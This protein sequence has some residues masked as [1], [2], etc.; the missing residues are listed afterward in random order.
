M[1]FV[2]LMLAAPAAI[3][4]TSW[5]GAF[6]TAWNDSRN[7]TNGVPDATDLVTIGPGVNN[8]V[9]S[10]TTAAVARAI[11]I[12]PGRTLT[13]QVSGSLTVNGSASYTAPFDFTAAVNN[14]GTIFNNGNLIL[15]SE[16]AIGTYGIVNQ[17]AFHNNADGI[18]RVD[19]STDT[20]I[21]HLAGF[22]YNFGKIAIGQVAN[23]GLHGIWNDNFFLNQASGEI[24]IG[25]V[26]MRGLVNNSTGSGGAS[27]SFTNLGNIAIG[28][29]N[30]AGMYGIENRA[31]FNSS[32]SITLD[33][34]TAS[35]LYNLGRFALSGSLV[36]GSIRATGTDGINNQGL[37]QVSTCGSIEITSGRLYNNTSQ[38]IVNVGLVN[39]AS[40]LE[41]VAGSFTNYG[42]LK[43]GTLSGTVVN[44][45]LIVNN[46]PAAT[47]VYG[48][49]FTGTINGIFT[50][51]EGT[52]SAG[53]FVAP[54]TI[55][56]SI[57]PGDYTLYAKVT[58]E[59]GACV[60]MVPFTYTVPPPAPD[61]IIAGNGVDISNGDTTPD[62]NDYTAFGSQYYASGQIVKRFVIRNT[63]A[64]PLNLTGTPSVSLSNNTDFTVIAEPVSPIAVGGNTFFEIAFDPTSAGA[65][66]AIVSIANNAAGKDP[67]TFTISGEGSGVCPVIVT[68]EP[69]TWTGLLDSDWNKACNWS[70]ASVPTRDNDVIIPTTSTS[71]AIAGGS[72]AFAKSVEL[73]TGASLTIASTAS[74]EVVGTK[75][76]SGV[77]TVF[78]NGGTLQNNGLL[79]LGGTSTTAVNGLL[80]AGSVV[81]T[82]CARLLVRSGELKN[83]SS[84]SITSTGFVFVQNTLSNNG[85]FTNNGVLKYGAL[86]GTVTNNQ[87]VVLDRSTS[88]FSY[89]GSFSGTV[90][91]IFLDPEATQSAGVFT[92]PNSFAPIGSLGIGLHALFAKVTLAGSPCEYLVA[93]TYEI[94]GNQTVWT[95]NESADWSN[96]A[97]WT[98]GV[99]GMYTEAVIPDVATHDP[100]IAAG[101]SALAN[102][103]LVEAAGVL[104]IST[105]GTLT[106]NGHSAYTEPFPF[107]FTAALNNEGTVNNAGSLII[108]SVA[109]AGM[110]GIVNQGSLSNLA[111][112][113][114][115]VDR[116]TDTG[117]FNAFGMW[118]NHGGIVLGASE[119]IGL[120][121][122]WND[123]IFNNGGEIRIDRSSAR[124]LM[125]NAD[126]TKS[127]H[128][129]FSN[130]A[131]ITIGATSDAGTTGIENR[132][133]FSNLTGA[134]IH[135]D[136][137][138]ENAIYHA[139]GS[140]INDSEITIGAAGASTVSGFVG[141]ADFTNNG[142]VTVDNASIFSVHQIVG[143]FTNNG[144][145][146]IGQTAGGGKIGF[147]NESALVNHAGAKIQVDRTI[148][149]GVAHTGGTF[150]NSGNIV[151]G[152]VASPGT[153]GFTSAAPV[154][155][156]AGGTI[157]VDRTVRHGIS[158]REKLFTNAGTIRVG[159]IASVGVIGVSVARLIYPGAFPLFVNSG[160][161]FADRATE[162]SLSS[163]S[164]FTNTG[165]IT[166]GANASPGQYGIYV[167]YG[168]TNEGTG[169]I[170]VD[171][172]T[173]SCVYVRGI[174]NNKG[175]IT[176]GGQEAAM[177]KDGI[178]IAGGT[179][180]NQGDGDI[181]IDRTP[182]IGLNLQGG[183]FNNEAN[184]VIG[185]NAGTGNWG[186]VTGGH[187]NNNAG[188][189]SVDGADLY[190]VYV[191]P[192]GIFTNASLLSLGANT[193]IGANG[194]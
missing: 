157:Q 54:N 177:G 51:K 129:T 62:V 109:G 174:F 29:A 113:E 194:I 176:V 158:H 119:A 89:G 31:E 173:Q 179:F 69:L 59:G 39:V 108:G 144:E 149:I 17:G 155:N 91:G 159:S 169:H 93:F 45:S 4:Q 185:A 41:V 116:T 30:S 9:I 106:V 123:A 132:G 96:T 160:K 128:A 175:K 183:V 98:A 97:N 145:V 83:E 127:I 5:T 42:I 166:L 131:T 110:Y 101:Q 81:N 161:I 47:F 191:R 32:G 49:N 18:I 85:T 112:G 118:T 182:Y 25:R 13:I 189:I 137:T 20:G 72:V 78:Y 46:Q 50:D 10:G 84:K 152:S 65:K 170:R 117:I 92:A 151:I 147:Q 74:L 172:A 120:H 66:T 95:G 187:F 7:W 125:N 99:P 126:E 115:R 37:L 82:S 143:V 48:S 163:L 87:I 43:Y 2:V 100:V 138:V 190:A 181:R 22:F 168:L 111:G 75:D 15:G 104:N 67:Y 27:T 53:S 124:A 164:G 107:N 3:A 12:E 139:T 140:F 33:D 1:T 52:Q 71:P 56:P 76:I 133:A 44:N 162:S 167:D 141:W 180:S 35:G 80:N 90:N 34:V 14:Y 94:S 156:L 36:T 134:S 68:T 24:T 192:Y 165:E 19:R 193:A 114:I 40:T 79:M 16:S 88:I 38:S 171:R 122:I 63:G 142:R 73:Q 57:P 28:S 77:T 146:L 55:V 6:G 21:F 153:Y 186:I 130:A 64:A 60:H 121:G 86:A 136:R 70:P 150:D 154:N 178:T 11:V 26:S 135:V 58:P 188:K 148:D 23:S 103:V 8:P 102:A 61:I 184:V 105:G